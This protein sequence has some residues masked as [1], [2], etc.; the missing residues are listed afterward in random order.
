VVETDACDVGIGAILSQKGHSLAFVSRSLG[1]R[2]KGL[3]VYEKEYLAILLVVQLWRPYLQIA[4]FMIRTGHK[5]L[6][7][8]TDQRLDTVWQQ[9]AFTKMMGLKYTVV[10]KKGALN[11]ASNALLHKP[12]R[13]SE[14]YSV[15]QVQLA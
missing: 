5:S 15:S 11:G 1:P 13:S 12:V 6:V 14:L 4:A 3:F 9:K 8:L 10:Y 7:H 2:H